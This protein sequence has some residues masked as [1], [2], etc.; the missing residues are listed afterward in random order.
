MNWAKVS[1]FFC[2][3]EVGFPIS[4]CAFM[5]WAK[6]SCFFC[7][8]EVGFPISFCLWSYIIF[9]T[10]PL[11]ERVEFGGDAVKTSVF[12]SL[13]AFVLFDVAVKFART[14]LEG[15]HS[16]FGRR[17][18]P[19]VRVGFSIRKIFFQVDLRLDRPRC[20]YQRRDPKEIH[21]LTM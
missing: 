4:G 16:I 13:Q 2:S 11:A 19:A 7:S 14:Q 9:S 5:N 10:I 15:A 12:G 1:C 6:V 8:S 20:R 18:H 21:E 3:S 17:R